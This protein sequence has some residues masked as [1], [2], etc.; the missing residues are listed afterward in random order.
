MKLLFLHHVGELKM[1]K[2]IC[3]FSPLPPLFLFLFLRLQEVPLE[4]L[5]A[6]TKD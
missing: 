5:K 4:G 6:M 3:L 1:A 2:A